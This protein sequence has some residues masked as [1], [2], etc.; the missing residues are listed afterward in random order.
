MLLEDYSTKDNISIIQIIDN[1]NNLKFKR[2]VISAATYNRRMCTANIIRKSKI[3]HIPIKNVT[4]IELQKYVDTLIKYSNSYINK[5]FEMIENA[6]RIAIKMEI[7]EKNPMEVVEKVHSNHS[8]KIVKSL[9]IEEQQAFIKALAN[10]PLLYQNIFTIA[11]HTGMRMGEILALSKQD[12]KDG[13]I[14]VHKTLSKNVNDRPYINY[15]TK[16]YNGIR[17]IPISKPLKKYIDSAIKNATN[18][19]KHL[20]FTHPDKSIIAV[21]TMNIIFKRICYKANIGDYKDYKNNKGAQRVSTYNQHMLRHTFATRCIEAKI[22]PEILQALLGHKDIQTTI[23]TYVTI[24]NK[25]KT[26]EIEK[27]TNYISNITYNNQ[28]FK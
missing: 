11:L 4:Y 21:S 28:N 24:F 13:Y 22:T 12:I 1:V 25:Y 14:F 3:S 27:Y 23:N 2:N 15:T 17:Y 9:S 8:P 6:F 18:N 10:E 19:Y 7:I 16:T 5:I 20:L 26:D